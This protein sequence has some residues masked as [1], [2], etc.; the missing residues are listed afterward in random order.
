MSNDANCWDCGAS[1]RSCQSNVAGGGD[2]CCG[3]CDHT[4]GDAFPPSPREAGLLPT[5]VVFCVVQG[6]DADSLVVKNVRRL[7]D[8]D[9]ARIAHIDKESFVLCEFTRGDGGLFLANL[10]HVLGFKEGEV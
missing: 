4:Q 7:S 6:E 3:G 10:A 9:T 2:R 8:M 5:D 1:A